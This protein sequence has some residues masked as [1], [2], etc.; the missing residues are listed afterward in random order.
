M[1]RISVV[2]GVAAAIALLTGCGDDAS[3][4]SAASTTTSM[5]T[6]TSTVPVPTTRTTEAGSTQVPQEWPS[7]IPVVSGGTYRYQ[8]GQTGAGILEVRGLGP[9]AFDSALTQLQGAGFSPVTTVDP[10]GSDPRTATLSKGQT[11]VSLTGSTT[12][13][14]YVLV[15]GNKLP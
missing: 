13:S 6:T 1:K 10:P 9:S 14:G 2:L 4:D 8:H 5:S 15:Y 3:E 7:D 11:V 12:A